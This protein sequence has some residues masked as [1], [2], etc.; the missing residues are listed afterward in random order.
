[1]L[2]QIGL[3]EELDAERFG[4]FFVKGDDFRIYTKGLSRKLRLVRSIDKSAV[5][6]RYGSW[7]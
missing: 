5:W 6:G 1:M 7:N 4:V 2:D 3:G